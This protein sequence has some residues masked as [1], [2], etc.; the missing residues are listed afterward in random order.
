MSIQIPLAI[1]SPAEDKLELA[2]L[3][4]KGSAFY[5]LRTYSLSGLFPRSCLPFLLSSS[6]LPLTVMTGRS[7]VVSDWRLKTAALAS[8]LLLHSDAQNNRLLANTKSE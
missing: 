5:V 1:A 6:N 8:Q 4:D 3:K 7:I 2:Y